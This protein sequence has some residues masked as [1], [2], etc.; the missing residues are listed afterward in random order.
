MNIA[1]DVE[2]KSKMLRVAFIVG[3]GVPATVIGSCRRGRGEVNL[4]DNG[5]L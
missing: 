3:E 1:G 2:H 5:D 4:P